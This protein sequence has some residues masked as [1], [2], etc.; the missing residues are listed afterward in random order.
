MMSD[1]DSETQPQADS[2]KDSPVQ[3]QVEPLET[4]KLNQPTLSVE[5]AYA[6][7]EKQLILPVRVLPGTTLFDAVVQSKI[8]HQFEGLDI[9]SAPMGVFGK[10][11]RKPKERILEDGD[12]VEI[13]RP[14]LVD[15]KEVRKRRA[16]KAAEEKASQE[17]TSEAKPDTKETKPDGDEG[18]QGA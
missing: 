15:P 18:Q 4:K 9:D 10:P 14:L 16:A 7:P 3:A 12:R 8:W 6:T 1:S 17:K 11:E 5:V 2:G 13:Y